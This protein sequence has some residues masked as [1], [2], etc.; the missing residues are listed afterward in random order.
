MSKDTFY[1]SHDHGARNDPKL[2]RLIVEL[3]AAAL[4]AYWC[5]VEQLYEQDGVL[6]MYVCKSTAFA[7][8]IKTDVVISIIKDFDLF[9]N[10]GETFWSNSVNERL[11]KRKKIIESR[12]K[13]AETR[14]KSKGDMQEQSTC[15]ADAMQNDANK[16]KE[17]ESKEN[18]SKISPTG[19]DRDKEE[20]KSKK[21][22]ERQALKV[23]KVEFDEVRKIYPG[24]KRG[25]DI[26][27]D[28]F[29]RRYKKE[30]R[31][32]LPL[33]LPAVRR[34]ADETAGQE[35]RFIKH[36]QTWINNRCWEETDG[37]ISTT[38]GITT[39]QTYRQRGVSSPGYSIDLPKQ[40]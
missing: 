16:I 13:A 3:G 21:E 23:A 18:K 6:P 15:N 33:L 31:K 29:I 12:K 8:H 20:E 7:L 4:G 36:L 10:D 32:I 30:W 37:A 22:E 5:L 34:Y 17:K 28:N 11:G 1:F 25:L 2:Q 40:S 39:T 38:N 19:D 24:K 14:W 27:F 35:K 26:E 9:E